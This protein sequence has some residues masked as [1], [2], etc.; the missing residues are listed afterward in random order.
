MGESS[1]A[2]TPEDLPEVLRVV[3]KIPEDE[4]RKKREFNVETMS[5][6]G[7]AEGYGHDGTKAHNQW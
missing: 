1:L 2:E 4:S 3:N 7:W 6:G 5:R